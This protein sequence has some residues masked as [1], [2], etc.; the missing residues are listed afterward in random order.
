MIVAID[1][2]VTTGVVWWG[3]SLRR[4]VDGTSRRD[5]WDQRTC[6]WHEVTGAD[7]NTIVVN[8]MGGLAGIQKKNPIDVIIIEDFIPHIKSFTQ[9]R[10]WLSPARIGAILK[11]EIRR[12][13]MNLGKSNQIKVVMQTPSDKAV[14]NDVRL[15]NLGVWISGMKHSRDAMRHLVLYALRHG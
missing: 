15:K 7:D 10:D 13:N 9:N 6:G 3:H 11:W 14:V 1:P 4:L 12:W 8:L 5:D 2:G